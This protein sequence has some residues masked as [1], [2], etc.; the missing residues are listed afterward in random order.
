[1]GSLQVSWCHSESE[2]LQFRHRTLPAWSGRKPLVFLGFYST[3]KPEIARAMTS[4]WISDAPSK[5]VWNLPGGMKALNN[6][7]GR[8]LAIISV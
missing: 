1:M 5:I 4:C 8:S 3:R 6:Y 7:G 2:P